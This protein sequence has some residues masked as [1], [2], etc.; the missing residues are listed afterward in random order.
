ML[1]E[2]DGS[3]NLWQPKTSFNFHEG[4][5]NMV[6]QGQASV[7]LRLGRV[8]M[9]FQAGDQAVSYTHLRAHETSAHL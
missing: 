1:A 9:L 7:G 3:L 2:G 5:A 4:L 8:S 6:H